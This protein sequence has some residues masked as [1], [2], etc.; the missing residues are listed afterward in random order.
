[1]VPATRWLSG[2]AGAARVA[3]AICRAAGLGGLSVDEEG[4]LVVSSRKVSLPRW[5]HLAAWCLAALVSLLVSLG[6]EP[7]YAAGQEIPVRIVSGD[8]GLTLAGGGSA[9][10]FSLAIPPQAKC[11]GD[12]TVKPWYRVYSFVDPAG[13]DITTVN[14]RAGIPDKGLGLRSGGAYFGAINVA[15]G[16]GQILALPGDFKLGEFGVA[17]LLP[18]GRTTQAYDVGIVCTDYLGHVAGHYWGLKVT[19]AASSNDAGGFTWTAAN[20]AAKAGRSPWALFGVL[21]AVVVTIAAISWARH[22]PAPRR[23]AR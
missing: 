8:Q 13:T 17:D 19:I 2:M 1:V 23:P 20:P 3:P 16:T 7:A 21:G 18:G 22:E 14:F 12:S 6:A 9:T 10:N 11:P 4:R 15:K 5:F